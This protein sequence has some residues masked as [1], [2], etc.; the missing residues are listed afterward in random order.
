MFRGVSAHVSVPRATFRAMAS[1]TGETR[2]EVPAYKAWNALGLFWK[3]HMLLLCKAESHFPLH[4]P[5]VKTWNFSGTI[6]QKLKQTLQFS[7]ILATLSLT[8]ELKPGHA[9]SEWCSHKPGQKRCTRSSQS[10]PTTKPRQ[11]TASLKRQSAS[12]YMQMPWLKFLWIGRNS[13][14]QTVSS[15]WHRTAQNSSLESG[16][17]VSCWYILVDSWF[18]CFNLLTWNKSSATSPLPIL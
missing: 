2:P 4:F 6:M 15:Y 5:D 17:N 7:I 3:T 13:T 14:P 10:F 18:L 16:N 9:P 11:T 1:S 12:T 8:I